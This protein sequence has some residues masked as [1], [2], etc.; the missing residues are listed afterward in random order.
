M[1]SWYQVVMFSKGKDKWKWGEGNKTKE[2][3]NTVIFLL[4][5]WQKKM[6]F[7]QFEEEWSFSSLLLQMNMKICFIET[8]FPGA[9]TSFDSKKKRSV[10]KHSLL[11]LIVN[12]HGRKI[13]T[14]NKETRAQMRKQIHWCLH[15][16]FP[17]NPL[18]PGGPTGPTAPFLKKVKFMYICNSQLVPP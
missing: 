11:N 3:I 7:L 10:M 6:F 16:T 2:T 13:K 12:P 18:G 1:Q 9:S 5:S 8:P 17:G 15:T 4:R 14:L